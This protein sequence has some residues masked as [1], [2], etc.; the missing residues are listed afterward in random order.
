MSEIEDVRST[1]ESVDDALS[2]LDEIIAP[3]DHVGGGKVAL[4][5]AVRLDV[6]SNP[7]GADAVVNRDAVCTRRLAKPA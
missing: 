4:N 5:A 7:L 1:F 2:F 6:L 3:C